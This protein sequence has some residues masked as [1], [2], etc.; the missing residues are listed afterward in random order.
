[1]AMNPGVCIWYGETPRVYWLSTSDISC[2]RGDDIIFFMISVECKS[3]VVR[4]KSGDWVSG[5]DRVRDGWVDKQEAR[6][7]NSKIW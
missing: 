5:V 4:D 7:I 3:H 6:K 1:M 2:G